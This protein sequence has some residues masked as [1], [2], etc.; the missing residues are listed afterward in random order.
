MK[1]IKLFEEFNKSI[2]LGEF[3]PNVTPNPIL[4]GDGEDERLMKIRQFKGS[5]EDYKNYWNDRINKG[6]STATN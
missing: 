6:N 1:K 5:F 2:G 3:K 4:K